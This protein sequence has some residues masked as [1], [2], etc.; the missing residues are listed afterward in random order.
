MH[1]K[2]PLSI[3]V[4][5]LLLLSI[6][7]LASPINGEPAPPGGGVLW[8]EPSYVNG[9]AVGLGNTF[10]VEL[11][12]N[13]STTAGVIGLEGC[14]AYAYWFG[15]NDTLLE[16]QSHSTFPP[17][18]IWTGGIFVVEDALKDT[19]ANTKNDLHSYSVTALGNPP[20]WKDGRKIAEY[21]FKVVYEPVSPEPT[22]SCA[23][24][25]T[26]KGF[27]D[28]DE[29]AMTIT[30][31]DGL[32]EFP[33]AGPPP[34]I[35]L[36]VEVSADPTTV[37]S[38]GTSTIT[39]YA[40]SDGTPVSGATV[41]LSSDGGGS[42]SSVVDH[43]NGNYTSTFTA[44]IVSTP[45]LVNIT[46]TAS[47]TG[48]IAGQGST[49]VTVEPGAPPGS[50]DINNDGVIDLLD[51]RICGKA[52]GSMAEDNPATSFDDTLNWNP[53]V[54]LNPDGLIDIFDLWKIAKH[55]GK[56]WPP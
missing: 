46:A 53:L 34:T 21:T 5:A 45:T 43:G 4:V 12:A 2:K 7:M 56:T 36:T 29:E 18:D 3:G 54:D 9:S 35:P 13:I 37:V 33:V 11:W 30:V 14:F 42:F 39:V 31:Y 32:Y 40:T 26:N 27:A 48:Y 19:D 6:L 44:P 1:T 55:Y 10:I 25:T 49:S 24:D 17:S 52:F 23:L 16:I 50:P 51:L 38:F 28:G 41:T 22:A 8:L 47:K 20:G 15:W